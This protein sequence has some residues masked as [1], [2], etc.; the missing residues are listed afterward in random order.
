M[1]TQI[2]TNQYRLSIKNA[3]PVFQY[4]ISLE[5]DTYGE[6]GSDA[7]IS[8]FGANNSFVVTSSD[9]EKIVQRNSRKI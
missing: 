7:A 4:P 5:P 3:P 6:S 2:L 8:G 9:M 1:K